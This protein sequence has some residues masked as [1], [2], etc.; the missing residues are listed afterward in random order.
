AFLAQIINGL[1]WVIEVFNGTMSLINEEKVLIDKDVI[2]RDVLQLSEALIAK[3]DAH[4]AT[5][6]DSGILPFLN[7]FQEI[8]ALYC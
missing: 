6:I 7:E 1:N 8:S 5:A 3:D 4:I 2:N